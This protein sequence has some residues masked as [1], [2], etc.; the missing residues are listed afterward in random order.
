MHCA[1]ADAPEKESVEK[2][3]PEHAQVILE[4]V[5]RRNALERVL[6]H[7]AHFEKQV[8]KLDEER[9][10]LSI[11]Y[12]ASDE[13]EMVIRILSF[14]PLVRVTDPPAFVG[15]IRERLLK[16]RSCGQ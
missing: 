9:Y 4:L 16:Q 5:D 14:G 8:E 13:T 1:F 12:D 15:L 2:Q 10:R 11:V 3:E 6:M 7:F